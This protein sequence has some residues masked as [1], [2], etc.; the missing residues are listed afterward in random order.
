MARG[1]Q[2][3]ISSEMSPNAMERRAAG[4]ACITAGDRHAQAIKGAPRFAAHVVDR[5]RHRAGRG[6]TF[7]VDDAAEGVYV[8]LACRAPSGS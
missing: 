6:K 7:T 3:G 4:G 8:G 2:L 5:Q 1:R